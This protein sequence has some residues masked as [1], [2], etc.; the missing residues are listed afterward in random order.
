MLDQIIYTKIQN[1]RLFTHV[2]GKGES[3]LFLHG[4]GASPVSYQKLVDTLA[5]NY[6]V[7]APHLPCFGYSQSLKTEITFE[8]YMLVMTELFKSY[9]EASFIGVGHSFGG[10][11]LAKLATRYPEKF[12]HLYLIDNAG[13]PIPRR[14]LADWVKRFKSHG[15][16]NIRKI[17][18]RGIFSAVVGDFLLTSLSLKKV[19]NL[20]LMIIELD[21]RRVFAKIK[22]PTTVIWADKDQTFPLIF[23]RKVHNLILASEF[24][25]IKRADHIWCAIHPE[26]LIK[27]LKSDNLQ[28]NSL[29]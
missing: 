11:V 4:W 5:K 16:K 27:I 17:Y 25:V 1:L 28:T 9:R 3:L 18:N 15:P 29:I 10:A 12:S 8:N 13:F 2:K 6:L 14:T 24:I 19:Y 7:Y 23:G 26:K 21:L 22:T 20:A